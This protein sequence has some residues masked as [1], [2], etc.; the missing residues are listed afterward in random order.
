MPAGATLLLRGPAPGPTPARR[1]VAARLLTWRRTVGRRIA[2]L[3]GRP[4][5]WDLWRLPP[6]TVRRIL[7]VDGAGVTVAIV[8]GVATPVRL[9]DVLTFAVFLSLATVALA[10]V[11]VAAPRHLGTPAPERGRVRYDLL[12][13][14]T[15]PVAVLLPPGYAVA[16]HLPLCALARVSAPRQPRHRRLFDAAG[17]GVAGFCAAVVH[18][19]LAP[20][21]GPVT[22]DTL[23]G[24]PARVGALLT[25]VATYVVVARILLAAGPGG[26]RAGALSAPAGPDRRVSAVAAIAAA[27]TEVCSAIVVAVLWTANPL[28]LL[29][30]APPALLLQQRGPMHADLLYAARTDAKTRLANAAYWREVAEREIVRSRRDGR[31]LSVL[32]LDI[33][34][35]KKVNDS[36]GHLTGDAVLLSVAETIRA[37]TRPRDLAG[38]FGGEEF[39]VLLSGVDLAAAGDVAER[40]RGQI[41]DLRCRVEGRPPIAVTVSVGVAAVGHRHTDLSAVLAAA[42]AALYRAKAA[43]RDRVRLA[44][45]PR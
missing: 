34:H 42:D 35:F 30:A 2:R 4:R 8:G 24:S 22:A 38:R 36:H 9:A 18:G 10:A 20:P 31:P 1:R 45:E 6:R 11:A 28:L 26:G 44:V 15:L 5:D 7:L 13:T 32:L 16:V 25:A 41:A 43:G 33:D 23:V 29:A 39:V 40:V 27:V 17:L 14:W 19:A 12:A 37:A 21:R 3:I